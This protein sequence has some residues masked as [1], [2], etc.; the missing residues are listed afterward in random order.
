MNH[1]KT[2]TVSRDVAIE[3]ISELVRIDSVTPWLVEG[4]AGELDVVAYFKDWVADL[5]VEVEV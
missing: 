3:M 4:G 2:T 5:A 1:A